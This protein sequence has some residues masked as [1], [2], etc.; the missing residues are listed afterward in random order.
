[1]VSTSTRDR[2]WAKVAKGAGCWLWTGSTSRGYGYVWTGERIETAHRVS[3]YFAH[4]PIP[5][6]LLVLHRCD[7][8]ACVNL[9]HLFL[10]TQRDNV[11]DAMAKGRHAVGDRNGARTKPH[12]RPRG[13]RHGRAKLTEA[14]VRAIRRAYARGALQSEIAREVGVGQSAVSLIVTG[15][16]WSHVE[17][18]AL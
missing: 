11:H 2:F 10:G 3:W 18:G 1:M 8:R 17:G 14:S 4:G 16:R 13:E 6:G 12:R 7:V 9:A 15:R 5:E